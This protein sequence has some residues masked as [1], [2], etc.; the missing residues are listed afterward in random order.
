[1]GRKNQ[2]EILLDRP[3]RRPEMHHVQVGELIRLLDTSPKPATKFTAP[4][5]S[6]GTVLRSQEAA[7]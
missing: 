1:M 4:E 5:E 7:S 6:N 3:I 2:Y